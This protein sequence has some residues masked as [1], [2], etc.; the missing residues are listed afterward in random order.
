MSCANDLT[1][2]A[3]RF[4]LRWR[5][6]DTSRKSRVLIAVSRLGHCLFDLLHRWRTGL[7]PVDI[8]G[9]VSNHEDMRSFVAWNDLPYIHPADL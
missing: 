7:L 8:V 1:A 9:V 2:I 5:L 4:A 6:T 3:R